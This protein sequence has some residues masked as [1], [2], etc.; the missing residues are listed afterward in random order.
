MIL[1]ATGTTP[2]E[3]LTTRRIER[4]LLVLAGLFVLAGFLS[5]WVLNDNGL[6]HWLPFA[7]WIVCAIT[8][9]VVLES[10]LPDRDPILFPVMMLLS[11]WGLVLIDR[12]APSFA[13]RQSIWL[14]VATAA[15][16]VS[17]TFPQII[18]WL[19]VYRYTLLVG[20]LSLLFA[21]ILLGSNPSGFGPELWLRLGP[22]FVQPSELLKI[23]LVV[24]L[25]SYL[26]EHYPAL[27]AQ[28]AIDGRERLWFSARI[29]GPILLMWSLSII[30]LIWQ[31]DLGTAVL[32]FAVFLTL[33][34]IASGQ[35]LIL[36]SGAGL[37][38]L[39]AFVAYQL[40]Q[41]VQ[42]RI[43]IWLNP[44][45]EADGRAFQIVQSL[46][47]FGAGGIFGQGVGQGYPGYI[48]VVHSDFIFSAVSEEWGFIGVVSIVACITIL[49]MRGLATAALN[50][51]RPFHV[52][53][54]AGLSTLIGVQ[55]LLIMAGVL[56]LIPLTGVTLPYM[57]YGGSS[58]LVSF[59]IGGLLLR[60][61]SGAK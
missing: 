5:L 34:Y 18:H 61:S 14:I 16:L 29:F 45:L 15:L 53:L 8:G 12:L 36:F 7:S 57:S 43:D 31:Q 48:P 59:I 35:T 13:D 58:L 23:V 2:G 49:V 24:F 19:R 1:G 46:M 25:A 47:A 10:R 39:A 55:S 21:T 28:T 27:R 37:I 54:G 44:W 17:A 26:G 20:G 40:F 60:L 52:L 4:S 3:S 32:F 51:A 9:T 6:V 22:I 41:V 30:I 42:L 50:H 33:L 38:A 11:G 56:K